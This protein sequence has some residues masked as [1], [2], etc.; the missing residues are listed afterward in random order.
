MGSTPPV[1]SVG[2]GTVD[3]NGTLQV[4]DTTRAKHPLGVD[5]Y[6]SHMAENYF[7]PSLYALACVAAN[8]GGGPA[9]GW[10]MGIQRRDGAW[11]RRELT[12][13]FRKLKPQLLPYIADGWSPEREREASNG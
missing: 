9:I 13:Y 4:T 3:A 8:Y 6:L 11:V 5:H 1:P 2:R 7:V 12:R 10:Q